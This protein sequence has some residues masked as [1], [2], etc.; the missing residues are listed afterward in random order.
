MLAA[1]T[2]PVVLLSSGMAVD[3]ARG[4]NA[5][6]DIQRASDAAVLTLLKMP[7]N[8]NRR[9][10]S[11]AA[12]AHVRNTLGD[13]FPI[14]TLTITARRLGTGEIEVETDVALRPYFMQVAGLSSL[15][16][17]VRSVAATDNGHLDVYLLL[18]RSASML[19]A[20]PGPDLQTMLD[21]T[22]ATMHGSEDADDARNK[23]PDGCAFACHGPDW[24]QEEDATTFLE[25]AEDNDI[26]LR[27][28]RISSSAL[29]MARTLLA[30]ERQNV[31]VGV[32]DFAWDARINLEPTD[33]LVAVEEALSNPARPPSN[34]HY[35]KLFELLET[36]LE[37]QGD[38]RSASSTR[39][40]L[41]LVTDG[42]YSTYVTDGSPR[43][44]S[45]MSYEGETGISYYESFDPE[46]CGP[47]LERDYDIVVVY[48]VYDEL[49]NSGRYDELVRPY[50]DEIEPNLRECATEHYLRASST[51]E[52]DRVFG[53][54]ADHLGYSRSVLTQ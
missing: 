6:A 19:L 9:A 11:A 49:I 33:D 40:V 50:A 8:A 28:D 20:Q 27:R 41:V 17:A 48:T 5:R 37:A 52:L 53:E 42:A 13:D 30:N 16:I 45:V 51:E 21:L 4:Y 12:E 34:T 54:L 31:R 2:I 18:D 38:G 1:L 39:K 32:I 35:A 22:L 10:L 47:L 29:Q 3:Y 15:D 26:T 23:E 43:P 44:R 46:L 36:E 14:D 7:R 24:W 25:I